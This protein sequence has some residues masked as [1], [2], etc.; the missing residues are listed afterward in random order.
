MRRA[1][2]C[3]VKSPTSSNPQERRQN[4]PKN[5]RLISLLSQARKIIESALDNV[6]WR[7]YSNK[8]R[9][10]ERLKAQKVAMLEATELQKRGQLVVAV[11]D[12]NGGIST[13]Y[14]GDS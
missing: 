14:Q 6:L 5:H 9:L 10:S 13:V 1:P 11:L 7:D 3:M 12:L 4:D 2:F 8:A